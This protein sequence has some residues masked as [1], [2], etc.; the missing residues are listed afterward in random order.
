MQS[1]PAWHNFTCTWEVCKPVSVTEW[2]CT[3]FYTLTRHPDDP[4]HIGWVV[5]ELKDELIAQSG[6]GQASI[7]YLN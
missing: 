1:F 4:A 3:M 5:S 7:H 6:L 2:V